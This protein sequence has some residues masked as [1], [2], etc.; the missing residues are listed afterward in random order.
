MNKKSTGKISQ[1]AYHILLKYYG[2]HGRIDTMLNLFHDL[3]RRGYKFYDTDYK[4]VID[5]LGNNGRLEEIKT[6]FE[7]MNCQPNHDIYQSL[8]RSYGMHG[9]LIELMDIF[10]NAKELFGKM[11]DVERHIFSLG[12]YNILLSSFEKAG[13]KELFMNTL[14]ETLFLVKV[15]KRKKKERRRGK[16]INYDIGKQGGVRRNSSSS[17]SSKF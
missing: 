6:I 13:K 9:K 7:K 17:K 5:S 10:E 1:D 4:V 11:K 16:G 14:N 15:R 12:T 3:G 2:I 8:M